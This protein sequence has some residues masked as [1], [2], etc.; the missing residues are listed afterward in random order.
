M[1]GRG[2]E[3][4]TLS[5]LKPQRPATLNA[6]ERIAQMRAAAQLEQVA[7]LRAAGALGNPDPNSTAPRSLRPPVLPSNKRK[8]ADS[9]AEGAAERSFVMVRGDAAPGQGSAASRIRCVDSS[10]AGTAPDECAHVLPLVVTAL[11]SLCSR[12]PTAA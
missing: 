6:G 2:W 4:P 11:S 10:C 7:R 9:P 1:L 5:S 3:H 8:S 12:I